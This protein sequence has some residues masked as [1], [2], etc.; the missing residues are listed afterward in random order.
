MAGASCASPWLEHLAPTP[1]HASFKRAA[2]TFLLLLTTLLTHAHA[3][4]PRQIRVTTQYIEVTQPALTE[5]L[6]IPSKSGPP[7]HANALE[8][9]KSGKGKILETTMVVC[10]SGKRATIESFREFIYP[11]EYEPPEL[12]WDPPLTPER[13]KAMGLDENPVNNPSA[14]FIGAYETRNVGETIEIEPTLA[15]SGRIIDLRFIPEIVALIG[16]NTWTHLKD[17]WGDASRRMPIF[18]TWRTNTSV[19]LTDGQFE[20]ASVITPKPIDPPP[21]ALRKILVFVRADIITLQP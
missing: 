14:R 16:L 1:T 11:T 20:L 13:R 8:L 2:P 5:L 18:D 6:N 4:P 9:C 21:A 17:D 19:T 12:V 3:A 10:R 15:P 7:L